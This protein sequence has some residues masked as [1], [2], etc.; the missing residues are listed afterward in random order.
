FFEQDNLTYT[1]KYE[2]LVT[3][4]EESLQAL[5]DFVQVSFEPS[6]LETRG[7]AQ[8][9]VPEHETWKIQVGQRLDPSRCYAWQKLEPS[10]ELE[11]ISLCCQ[12]L[13]QEF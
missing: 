9:T 5:C 3:Q 2:N 10:I 13:I 11:A 12:D 6:M 8:H 4:P 7:A 1:L